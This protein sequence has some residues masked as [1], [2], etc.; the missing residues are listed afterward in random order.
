MDRL[1]IS[2]DGG[3]ALGIGPAAFLSLLDRADG[4]TRDAL[5][6][7][8]YAGS[9]VGALLVALRATGRTWTDVRDVFTAE[10]E[11]IFAP[12][13]FWWRVNPWRPR[14]DGRALRAVAQRTFGTMEMGDLGVPVFLTA[15]DFATGRVKVWDRTDPVPVWWAV[16]TS[17]AAPTYFPIVDGRYGDGGLAANNPAMVG[18][19]ACGAQLGWRFSDMRCLSLGTNG[20]H[21]DRLGH[22]NCRSKVGWLAPLLACYFDGGEERDTYTVR[23]VLGDR[24]RRVE[25]RLNHEY[26]MD[27]AAAALGPYRRVWEELYASEG[28]AVARWL[29]G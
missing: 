10:C 1:L 12:A 23:A 16:L 7:D 9:S 3:G 21:W 4:A 15:F 13:P 27:D 19:A 18:V 26:A 29:R 11:E 14:Y 8:A 28:A 24:F 6:A 22:L 20:Q 25:P 5:G 17:T 2:I